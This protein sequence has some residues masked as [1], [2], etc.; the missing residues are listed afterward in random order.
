MASVIYAS[1]LALA[2]SVIVT[3]TVRGF[4]LRFGYVDRPDER[5]R[6]TRAVPRLGG[7]GIAAGVGAGLAAA[8]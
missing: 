6:H 5:K 2:V 1:A 8:A 7:V 4:A 3:R